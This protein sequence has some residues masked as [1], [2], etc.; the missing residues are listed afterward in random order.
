VSSPSAPEA[1]RPDEAAGPTADAHPDAT[2]HARHPLVR[3]WQYGGRYR[4]RIVMAVL[5]TT[6]NKIADVFPELLIGAAV[7]VVVQQQDSFVARVTGIQS[8][9]GMLVA[10]AAINVVVWVIESITDY[11]AATRWRRLA[12]SVQ[13]DLRTDTYAHLQEL[14]VGWFEDTT[15][16]GLL[17]VLNDDV[18]Q[19]ERFLDTGAETIIQ[20][21]WNI[22]IVGAVFFLVSW[23]LAVVAF[24]PIPVIVAGSLRYQRRLEPLY[25]VVRERVSELSATLSANLGGITTI[26]AFAAE[27]REAKRVETV[28]Q[29]YLEAN[30]AAIRYSSA[31]V[32]IIRMAILAG[33]TAT[34]LIGGWLVIEGTLAVGLY[35]VLVFMTQRLLWPLTDLGKTLDLYQRG[36]ASTRRILDL[37]DVVPVMQPGSA[38]LPTPVRGE[39][40]LRDVTFG[41]AEGADVLRGINLRV[42][43]GETHAIVGSTGAGKSTLVRL[44]LRF[45]DPRSGTV[46]LDGHD[47]RTLTYGSLRGAIG[48]V[49]QDVFLFHGSVRDNIAYGRPDATDAEIEEAAGLAEAHDFVLDLPEGYATVVGERGVKLSGGQRQRLSIARAILRDPAVLLLDEATSAVDN[50]TEAAIQRSLARV[51]EGRTV[52]VIAHRLS[53]VRD[54]DRIWV[55]E[56]GGVAESGTHDELVASDGLYAALWRV[57]TGDAV[58]RV[59]T[60]QQ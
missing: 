23:Q 51:G 4:R 48:Y 27:R 57:Q 8:T 5:W 60:P 6:L 41:Y 47:V 14:E 46:A 7:D 50:E 59:H 31:F 58:H 29:D 54:A 55:L 17:A 2:D 9:F 32:P 35:S 13:H 39:L 42:P 18:N 33:F 11:L 43:A 22:V 3:L 52:V 21:F 10:L 40:E 30:S 1:G 28:S 38:A 34:L 24:L 44:L 53:T 20:L 19:L 15:S 49:A 26:K 45:H 37:L 36:M 56:A 12:Q 16:G 25:A